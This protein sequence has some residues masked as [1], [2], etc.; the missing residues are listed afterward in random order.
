MSYNP[1]RYENG[2]DPMACLEDDLTPHF[3]QRESCKLTDVILG[4][5]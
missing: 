1:I 4:I 2:W 5:K 3:E